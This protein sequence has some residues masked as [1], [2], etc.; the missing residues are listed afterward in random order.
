MATHSSI[1]AWKIPWTEEPGEL[2]SKGWQRVRHTTGRQSNCFYCHHLLDERW[3]S[4]RNGSNGEWLQTSIKLRFPLTS[5]HA[6]WFLTDQS[7]ILV[8]GLGVGN[9]VLEACTLPLHC[10]ALPLF[11]T[12]L[13]QCKNEILK[14]IIVHSAFASNGTSWGSLP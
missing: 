5:C 3:R 12:H 9:P 8:C 1:P 2:Q 7:L 14:L 6:T 4:G 10:L 13:P 11:Y